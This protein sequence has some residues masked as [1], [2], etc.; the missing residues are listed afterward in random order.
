MI[1]Q[2]V[3]LE[4]QVKSQIFDSFFGLF[5]SKNS[6]YG[7]GPIIGTQT[8]LRE[9]V[10]IDTYLRKNPGKVDKNRLINL[11]MLQL[12]TFFYVWLS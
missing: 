2:R 3:F 10:L 4:F 12:V 9:S 5:S 11:G 8:I 6:G 1:V 7:A